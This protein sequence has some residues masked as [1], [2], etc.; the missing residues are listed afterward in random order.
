MRVQAIE[1][2]D[3]LVSWTVIRDSEGAFQWV[4]LV[5]ERGGEHHTVFERRGTCGHVSWGDALDIAAENAR[6][7][8]IALVEPAEPGMTN[9]RRGR[10]QAVPR[11]NH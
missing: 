6:R 10:T 8:A 4:V 7:V 3:F 11:A 2:A 5:T 9:P 1:I